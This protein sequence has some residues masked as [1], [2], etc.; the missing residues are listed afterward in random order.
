MDELLLVRPLL[1]KMGFNPMSHLNTFGQTLNGKSF[2]KLDGSRLKISRATYNGMRYSS[3]DD[4]HTEL[5]EAA[6]ANIGLDRME[7]IKKAFNQLLREAKQNSMSEKG[8]NRLSK[9]LNRFRNVSCI[10]L[11]PAPLAKVTPL[12]IIP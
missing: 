6:G 12:T 5:L 7:D 11:G 8:C 4:D 2:D 1:K 3:V 10:Q 9:A